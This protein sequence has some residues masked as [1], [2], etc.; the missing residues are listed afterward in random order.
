MLAPAPWQLR[1][2]AYLLALKFAETSPFTALA[3]LVEPRIGPLAFALFVDYAEAP[4]GPYRELLFIPGTYRFGAQRWPSIT[5]IYVSTQASIDNGRRNWAIPKELASFD[6][7]YGV[8]GVDR[9]RMDV[10]GVRAVELVFAPRSPRVPCASWLLP[11]RLRTLAQPDG[12]RTLITRPRAHGKLQHARVVEAWS[13]GRHFPALSRARVF[14]SFKL[15]EV[16]LT[17]PAAEARPRAG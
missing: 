7:S 15:T 8:D 16:A 9:I 17:F 14:A 3:G 2:Q 13:D 1:A 10:D 5:K 6:V 11:P 4:V 12:E